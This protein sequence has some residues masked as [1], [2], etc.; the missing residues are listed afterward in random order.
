[1]VNYDQMD[2]GVLKKNNREKVT[3]VENLETRSWDRDN[4][5]QRANEVQ[6]N[7]DTIQNI[8]QNIEEEIK[9]IPDEEELEDMWSNFLE[10]QKTDEK[11]NAKRVPRQFFEAEK[12]RA[13]LWMRYAVWEARLYE[14]EAFAREKLAEKFVNLLEDYRVLKSESKLEEIVDVQDKLSR[15]ETLANQID[16]FGQKM[17]EERNS[18]WNMVERVAEKEGTSITKEDIEEATQEGIEEFVSEK[19]FFQL[20]PDEREMEN[21]RGERDAAAEAA[22]DSVVGDDGDDGDRFWELKDKSVDKQAEVLGEMAEE[23]EPK[24]ND[25][26]QAEIA[27]CTDVSQPALFKDGGIVDRVHDENIFPGID[28]RGQ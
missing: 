19:G 22:A 6:E 4:I 12:K 14:L 17:H 25:L 13:E 1:M 23:L 24:M 2:D 26:T 16:K 15:M 11:G 20:D 8:L 10:R 21:K 3:A 9:T 7:H 5:K 18:L 27:D 28:V